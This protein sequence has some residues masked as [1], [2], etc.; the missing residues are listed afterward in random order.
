[1]GSENVRSGEAVEHF[2]DRHGREHRAVQAWQIL[3]GLAHNRQ[4]VT[5][6][7]MSEMMGYGIGRNVKFALD[8]IFRFCAEKGLP[9]LTALVVGVHSG[10]PGDAFVEQHPDIPGAQA[11]VYAHDWYAVYPPTSEQFAALIGH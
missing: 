3:I 4:T 7:S 6:D 1:M 11:R 5:Y 9:P 8:P 2:G 10:V